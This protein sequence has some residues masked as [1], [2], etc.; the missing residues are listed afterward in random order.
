MRACL[1]ALAA[2]VLAC[3][4]TPSSSPPG[5][6]GSSGAPD[7]SPP[8]VPCGN[9]TCRPDEYCHV[10]CTCCGAYLREDMQGS[11]TTECLPVTD[12]CKGKPRSAECPEKIES[13]C[14]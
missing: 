12:A 6:V 1:I 3:G 14:A 9:D 4:H 7:A 13:P 10:Q 8:G 5:N 11:F 2:I